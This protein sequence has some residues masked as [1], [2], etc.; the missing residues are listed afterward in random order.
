MKIKQIMLCVVLSCVAQV[1][2][3]FAAD[4][5]KKEESIEDSWVALSHSSPGRLLPNIKGFNDFIKSQLEGR[6]QVSS[7]EWN[8][9]LTIFESSELM[10]RRLMLEEECPIR[11]GESYL[12]STALAGVIITQQDPSIVERL[13]KGGADGKGLGQ[14]MTNFLDRSIGLNIKDIP[15]MMTYIDGQKMN[16]LELARY[17]HQTLQ[18]PGRERV[19]A[20][21]QPLFEPK[22]EASRSSRL[23]SLFVKNNAKGQKLLN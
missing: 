3:G 6:E 16:M 19:I 7:E 4:A 22:R 18:V 14:R 15:D 12:V 20:C 10:H 23:S 11:F 13:I 1:H 2:T 21:L 9:M 8:A 5:E 17:A